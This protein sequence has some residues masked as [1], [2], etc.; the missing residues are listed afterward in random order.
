MKVTLGI[1]ARG[2]I[3]PEQVL[4]SLREAGTEACAL[5]LEISHRERWPTDYTVVQAFKESVE[6]WRRAVEAANVGPTQ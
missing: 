1:N 3:V 6:H 4:A 5:L 2:K